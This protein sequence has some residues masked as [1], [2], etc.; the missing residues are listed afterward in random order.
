MPTPFEELAHGCKNPVKENRTVDA[1]SPSRNRKTYERASRVIRS[2]RS[3]VPPQ[4]S[5]DESIAFASFLAATSSTRVP[6]SVSEALDGPNSFDWRRVFRKEYDS[7]R[8]KKTWTCLER[9]DVPKDKKVLSGKVVMKTKRNKDGEIS[10]IKVRWVVRGFEQLYGRDYIQ[11]YA[12]VCRSTSW[13]IAISMA[14]TFNLE[15]DQMDAVTAFLNSKTNDDI[16]VELPPMW[17]EYNLEELDDPVCKLLKAL[18]GLKQALHLWQNHLRL[19]LSEDGLC[20][21]TSSGRVS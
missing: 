4:P 9:S 14:A 12:G 16:Y 18:Y 17:K 15:I 1:N 5:P 2:G 8:D 11:T 7:L 19:K 13:K 3:I 21:N 6:Q 10:K 20:R